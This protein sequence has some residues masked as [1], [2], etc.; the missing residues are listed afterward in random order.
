MVFISSFKPPPKV[1][2]TALWF[3]FQDQKL[4]IKNEDKNY[5]VLQSPDLKALSLAP[6]RQQYLGSLDGRPCY[7]AELSNAAPISDIFAFQGLRS[8]FGRLE[9]E[10]IWIIEAGN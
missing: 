6:V 7:A 10:L 1:E 5:F 4:L 2:K 9:E 8:L 3:I